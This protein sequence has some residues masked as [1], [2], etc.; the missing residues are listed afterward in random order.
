MHQTCF[1]RSANRTKHGKV[2]NRTGDFP[3]SKRQFQVY[4]LI[5]QSKRF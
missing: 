3:F 4:Y 5:L 2:N 1:L